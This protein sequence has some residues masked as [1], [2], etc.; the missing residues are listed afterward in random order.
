MTVCKF[1]FHLFRRLRRFPRLLLFSSCAVHHFSLFPPSRYRSSHRSTSALPH[2]AS[3]QP[4]LQDAIYGAVQAAL[5]LTN[6]AR[7]A[8]K[9]RCFVSVLVWHIDCRCQSTVL[10]WGDMSSSKMTLGRHTSAYVGTRSPRCRDLGQRTT[11]SIPW[12][13]LSS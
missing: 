7:G 13:G 1:L 8:L 10:V 5:D 3:P 12:K 9:Y 4:R 6:A 2:I 11:D